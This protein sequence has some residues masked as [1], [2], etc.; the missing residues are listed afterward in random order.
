MKTDYQMRVEILRLYRL[1]LTN[2]SPGSNG[3]IRMSGPVELSM[4]LGEP[5]SFKEVYNLAPNGNDVVTVHS[6]DI[7]R[8]FADIVTSTVTGCDQAVDLYWVSMDEITLSEPEIRILIFS[9]GAV[10]CCVKH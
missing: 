4:S 8:V 10:N 6:C 3:V 9:P 1:R 5:S 7:H 2:D